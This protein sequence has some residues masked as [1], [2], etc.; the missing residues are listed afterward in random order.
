MRGIFYSYQS[1]N[2][3]RIN[4]PNNSNLNDHQCLYFKNNQFRLPRQFEFT[5]QGIH[6][7]YDIYE[8]ACRTA[9]ILEFTLSYS[10]LNGIAIISDKNHQSKTQ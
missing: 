8:V 3:K 9:G 5:P 1:N 6:F 2:P 7:L 10:D 4:I